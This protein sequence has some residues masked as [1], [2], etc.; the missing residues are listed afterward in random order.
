M[1]PPPEIRVEK[2]PP[3]RRRPKTVT[4]H[5]GCCCCCCCCLHSLGGLIGAAVGSAPIVPAARPYY[6]E[7]EDHPGLYRPV[8]DP[9]EPAS[10]IGWVVG[11]Y[12]VALVVLSL[13]VSVTGV[14]WWGMRGELGLFGVMIILPAIQAVASVVNLILVVST[15]GGRAD[16]LQVGKIFLGTAIGTILGV[17]AM[18]FMCIGIP[19]IG[20]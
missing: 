15:G 16:L 11:T 13:V 20:K 3:E 5:C 18:W 9:G 14:P 2:H 1:N 17:A 6:V 12:W 10:A 4:T 7:D 19:R 8:V